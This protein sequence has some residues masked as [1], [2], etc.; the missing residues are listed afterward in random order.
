MRM[1]T[2]TMTVKAC[3]VKRDDFIS[4]ELVTDV[5]PDGCV[6]LI[7]MIGLRLPARVPNEWPLTIS[8]PVADPCPRGH[9]AWTTDPSLDG[10]FVGMK[11]KGGAEM[12]R[13]LVALWNEAEAAQPY[14]TTAEIEAGLEKQG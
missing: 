12:R 10:F 7:H 4:G 9:L 5:R 2:E 14:R 8:R 11:T 3:E 1:K 6:I 13:R